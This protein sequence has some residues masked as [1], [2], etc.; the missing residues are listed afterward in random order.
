M[1][2]NKESDVRANNA[3]PCMSLNSVTK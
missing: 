3:E 2:T 1:P